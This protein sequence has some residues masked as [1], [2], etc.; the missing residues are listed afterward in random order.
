[1]PEIRVNL[2]S[3]PD[4]VVAT[5]RRRSVEEQRPLADIAREELL[6]SV[7][8]MAAEAAESAPASPDEDA[9]LMNALPIAAAAP[10]PG[11]RDRRG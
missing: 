3:L 4:D 10:P 5:L 6:S 9:E 2:E 8:R 7:R 11:Y 1:M